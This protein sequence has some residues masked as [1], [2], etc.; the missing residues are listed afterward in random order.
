MIRM[1]VTAV[2]LILLSTTICFAQVPLRVKDKKIIHVGWESPTTKFLR[3]SISI[4]KAQPFDGIAIMFKF[5][6]HDA[7]IC[8]L[9]PEAVTKSQ[10]QNQI[11]DIK[12]VDFGKLTD[13]FLW[14]FTADVSTLNTFD[15][16][17]DAQWN[18]MIDNA[19]LVSEVVKDTKLKGVIF[20]TEN[21]AGVNHPWVMKNKYTN[22]A[23]LRKKVRERGNQFINALENSDGK[24]TILT[25]FFYGYLAKDSTDDYSPLA[26][27]FFDGMLEGLNA[28]S[29]IIDGIE[30]HYWATNAYQFPFWTNFTKKTVIENGYVS[31]E[32]KDKYKKQV[33]T[34]AGIFHNY[35]MGLNCNQQGI[36]CSNTL[37]TAT[38]RKWLESSIYNALINND[39]Y[40]WLYNQGES[41]WWRDFK[42]KQFS[43]NAINSAKF[44]ATN[45]LPLGFTIENRDTSKYN[46]K[47]FYI[48]NSTTTIT[49]NSTDNKRLYT[50]GD[51]VRF[52]LISNDIYA[53]YVRFHINGQSINQIA[54]SPF[55]YNLD[56]LPSGNYEV[57]TIGY[58]GAGQLIQSNSVFFKIK[59]KT[60]AITPVKTISVQIAPNPISHSSIIFS[61]LTPEI[62]N[63][64]Y[65]IYNSNGTKIQ[66]G[67]LNEDRVEITINFSSGIYFIL[68][69]T[70]SNEIISLKFLKE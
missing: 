58:S 16:F 38:K 63:S 21:Y 27:Y 33:G 12:A 13:N 53:N 11:D 56:S 30:Q 7:S 45:E 9:T 35:I 20:D 59:D 39:E 37:D 26:R 57:Y 6:N 31:N 51:S 36:D 62:A 32:L 17:D 61:S 64:N 14:L 43:I 8:A 60:S 41:N 15:W 48:D 3:D 19:K 65:T 22:L 66:E 24:I 68:L 52:K 70:L 55:Y 42:D 29:K 46:S 54:F 4:I 40:V 28:D 67:K 69:Q 23:L 49:L 5:P 25:T 10:I 18:I 2:L 1:F 34:S 50:K 44:K 47:G